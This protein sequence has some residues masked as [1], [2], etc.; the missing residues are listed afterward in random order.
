MS[1]QRII[2]TSSVRI[3]GL[4]AVTPYGDTVECFWESILAGKHAFKP[5]TLFSTSDHRTAIAAEIEKKDFFKP[6]TVD[7]EILSRADAM[8]MASAAEALRHAGLLGTG[9]QPGEARQSSH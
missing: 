8:A 6:R 2:K 4:G 7:Q 5:I 1:H 3:T 9:Y